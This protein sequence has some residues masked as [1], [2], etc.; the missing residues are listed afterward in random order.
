MWFFD[1]DAWPG[2]HDYLGLAIAVAGFWIAIDQIIRSRK[3]TDRATAAL[4]VAQR[5]LSQRS[6]M[7]AV[8]Q[9]QSISE[10]LNFALPAN[11]VDVAHRSLVRFSLIAR[12]T[13]GVLIGL[14]TDHFELIERLDAAAQHATEAKAQM[15]TE[16]EPNV[17]LIVKSVA[18]EVD[19]IGQDIA[20]L[21]SKLRNTVEGALDVQ[22]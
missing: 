14:G 19:L 10:D 21:A 11:S 6:I 18:A 5:H 2:W 8:P 16:A 20:G 12:E 1:G 9:F 22:R 13:S 15:L 3:S 17:I 7:A 4:E